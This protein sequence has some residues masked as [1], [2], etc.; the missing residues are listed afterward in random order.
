MKF[1]RFKKEE[2]VSYGVL[3]EGIIREIKGDIYNDYQ[4]S[5]RNYL[6]SEVDLLAPCE[7]SKI[8]CVGLNYRDHAKELDM[9]LPKEPVI[10]LKPVTSIIGPNTKVKYPKISQQVDYEAEL[11]VVVKNQIREIEAAEVGDYILGYTCFNDITARDL[12]NRDGQWTRAKSFDTFAPVGP[13]IETEV[14]P[15]DLQV[16]LF[17]NGKVKQNSH[18]KQMI[19]EI[20]YLVSFISQVMTLNPGDIIATGTPPGVGSVE[21]GDDLEV[22]IEG[23][24]S[25]KSQI[26]QA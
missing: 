20:E 6:L 21:V 25:L 24:G 4:I 26:D 2:K 22:K 7:P 9:D 8:I 19:F 17:H 18:T 12:Q 1:L 23:I 13:I 11:A 5:D 3:E 10:F 15:N 14:N 16:Q